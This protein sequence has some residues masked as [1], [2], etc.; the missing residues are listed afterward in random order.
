MPGQEQG[1]QLLGPGPE[2]EL[3]AWQP[4]ELALEPELGPGPGLEPWQLLGAAGQRI[5]SSALC[6]DP[7]LLCDWRDN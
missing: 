2:L 1:Q 7:C 5:L 6:C 4:R 3:E